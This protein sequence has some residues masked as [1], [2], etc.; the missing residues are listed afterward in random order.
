MKNFMAY[1]FI[2]L[3][4]VR[5]MFPFVFGMTL[6]LTAAIGLLAFFMQRAD[7][8]S[9]NKTKLRIALVGNVEESYLG[10]GI[11]AIQ[12]IDSSRFVIDLPTMTEEEAKR[13]LKQGKL[14]AYA[15]I[16]EGFV[17]SVNMGEN[18]QIY[19]EA[20]NASTA[21]GTIMIHELLDM[22]SKSV[23][24]SQNAIYGTQHFLLEREMRDVYMDKV[25]ELYM[26]LVAIIL[27][28]TELYGV[29]IFGISDGLSLTEYY[30]IAILILFLSLWG[31]TCSMIFVKKNNGLTGFLKARGY[32]ISLQVLGEYLA[33][34]TLMMVNVFLMLLP[35]MMIMKM[36]DICPGNWADNS[37]SSLFLF[38]VQLIPVMM[39]IA[40]LQYF[41]YETVSEMVSG[42]V[43]QFLMA[44]VLTYLSGCFYPISFFPEGIQKLS[45][46]LPT[47]ASM[48]YAGKCML[49]VAPFKELG[50]IFLY[51]IL[52]LGLTIGI[53]KRRI[54]G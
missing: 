10:F 26:S 9:E 29:K 20:N 24:E 46:W 17:D 42:I 39:V 33:Y 28:R 35:I 16:P 37:F 21:V 40:A 31:I 18:K 23:T 36:L 49:S 45:S 25:N 12:K 19:Y 44:I 2:Q 22:I 38:A 13:E 5:K 15:I 48:D 43:V 3:K 51:I 47:G 6:L 27:N 4:R 30:I 14:T 52:F 32:R 50:V 41:L 7:A 1:V 54:C 34:L 53:R 8:N 11:A